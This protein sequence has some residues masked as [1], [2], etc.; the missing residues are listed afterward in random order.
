MLNIKPF[1]VPDRPQRITLWG[2]SQMLLLAV[3]LGAFGWFTG[4][5][6]SL[7]LIGYVLIIEGVF[8]VREWR[9]HRYADK[10][11]ATFVQIGESM[12]ELG[13]QIERIAVEV[14]ARMSTTEYPEPSAATTVTAW[15]GYWAANSKGQH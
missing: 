11:E 1:D 14:E 9:W 3:A 13:D 5:W 2:P 4:T 10:C 6:L 15:N 12:D 7:P 8:A